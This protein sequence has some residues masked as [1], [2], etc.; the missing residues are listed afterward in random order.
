MLD[1]LKINKKNFPT[2]M[3]I[4]GLL[5]SVAAFFGYS[6]IDP[7][8]KC[9][10]LHMFYFVFCLFF[11][12]AGIIAYIVVHK[13]SL[14]IYKKI[15]LGI[16]SVIIF[17]PAVLLLLLWIWLGGIQDLYRYKYNDDWIIGRNISEVEERYGNAEHINGTSKY[18]YFLYHENF[19]LD[20]GL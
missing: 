18:G 14:A 3:I 7:K 9:P 20:Q 4:L 13:D 17:C 11:L 6:I 10:E 8:G 12:T 2:I 15:L 5:L 1:K 16:V 19:G